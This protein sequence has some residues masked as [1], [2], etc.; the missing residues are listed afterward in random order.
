M[1]SQISKIT[2]IMPNFNWRVS[3][4][5][6]KDPPMGILYIA[7]C[8]ESMGYDVGVID[9]HAEELTIDDVI[10]KIRQKSPHVVG[11]SCNYAP[12]HNITM[13][14]C[15]KIKAENKNIVTVIGGNHASAS[16]QNL[17]EKCRSIDFVILGQGEYIFSSLIRALNS[18]PNEGQYISNVKG[19]AYVSDGNIL[20]TH[21]APIIDNL[22]E[23]PMPAYHLVDMSKY[24]RYNIITSRGCPYQC[25]YCAS[26]VITRHHFRQRTPKYVVN[27][28]KHVIGK[29]GNKP[30]WFSDDTFTANKSFVIDLMGRI[31]DSGI[32]VEWSCLTR[33]NTTTK[34]ILN[35]MK[36][37]GCKYISYGVESGNE[38]MLKLMNKKITIHNVE[39]VL[40]DT[41]DVGIDMY[42]FFI[43]G[44]PGDTKE[45]AEDGIKLIERL[46]PTGVGYNIFIPL[47]GTPAWK[48]LESKGLVGYDIIEWDKLFMR[49][50]W[51][52]YVDYSAKLAST[53]C[54]MTPEEII[55]IC[56]RGE[57]ACKN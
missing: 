31:I 16:Y 17:L 36:Q 41:K 8:L 14:L 42:L 54:D 24:D 22:D 3:T 23:L 19:I 46:C 40:G 47:P 56:Q 1:P 11:I 28:I 9:A 25:N 15:E 5:V 55:D 38:E 29:Y 10:S 12:L 26:N 32:G 52:E 53:W 33:V 20:R 21:G 50:A 48:D 43:V 51:S 18:P 34:E 57:S 2:L 4:D 13:E 30:V 6:K 44:Y 27:E 49:T 45:M 7:S 37:A 35:K 39:Q